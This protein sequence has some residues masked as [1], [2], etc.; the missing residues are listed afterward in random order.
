MAPFRAKWLT[1]LFL[2]LAARPPARAQEPPEPLTLEQAQDLGADSSLRVLRAA[3]AVLTTRGTARTLGALSDPEV[4]YDF[5]GEEGVPYGSQRFGVTQVLEFPGKRRLQSR[6]GADAVDMEAERLAMVRDQVRAAIAAPFYQVARNDAVLRSFAALDT[7]FVRLLEITRSRY[8]AGRA[9]YDDVLRV[10]I[11][12]TR[13]AASA[14]RVRGDRAEQVIALDVLLGRPVDRPL[15]VSAD[16]LRFDPLPGPRAEFVA[17]RLAQS[18]SLRIARTL[19]VQRER[20]LALAGKANLP[21]FTLDAALQHDRAQV[22]ATYF[23]GGIALTLPLWRRRQAGLIQEARGE[24]A[25]AAI[26]YRET[27]A[28]VAGEAA[29][30]FEAAAALAAEVQL[31]E[32]RLLP[33]IEAGLESAI[34]AY[35]LGQTEILDV[36][37]LLRT[38]RETRLEH[39]SLLADYLAGRAR[40]AFAGDLVQE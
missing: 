5:E 2:P 1:V 11:E 6:I 30:A 23:S 37:D 13:V 31:F 17:R 35:G 36:I 12:R 7:L 40:L 39:L 10:Q 15:E 8:A 32:N 18:H 14:L 19:S 21:D 9:T 16:A 26:G 34:Q 28:R 3:A 24:S 20:A 27:E 29:R 38:L 22:H 4:W 33:Q 25:E